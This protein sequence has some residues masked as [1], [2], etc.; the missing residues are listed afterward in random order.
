MDLTAN[1]ISQK[2]SAAVFIEKKFKPKTLP[3][4]ANN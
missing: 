1:L 2:P 3:M 4:A